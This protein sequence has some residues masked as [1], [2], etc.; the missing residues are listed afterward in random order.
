MQENILLCIYTL[1]HVEGTQQERVRSI[2]EQLTGQSFVDLKATL[3]AMRNRGE[4]EQKSY[5][6]RTDSYDY[7]ISP[8]RLI[9]LMIHYYEEEPKLTIQVLEAA[10]SMETTSVQRMLWQFISTGYSDI[11]IEIIS[12]YQIS[13]RLPYFMPAVADKRFAPLLMVFSLGNFADL[14]TQTIMEAIEDEGIIDA[15]H[16]RQLVVL[17]RRD[18]DSLEEEM[19]LHEVLC[20]CGLYTYLADGRMPDYVHLDDKYH[21]I[22]A[23]IR[24]TYRGNMKNALTMFRRSLKKF[25]STNG[26]YVSTKS[27]L[28]LSIANFYYI[29]AC[30]KDGSDDSNKK[31]LAIAKSTDTRV[32][33]AAKVLYNILYGNATDKQILDRLNLL[34]ASRHGINRVLATLMCRYVGKDFSQNAKPQWAILIHEMSP[35]F[36]DLS[37]PILKKTPFGEAPLLSAIHHRKQWENVLSDLTGLN[38]KGIDV[39]IRQVRVSRVAY[40]LSNMKANNVTPR[41]QTI[42]KNGTWGS[43]KLL[44]INSFMHG[45]ADGMCDA[46]HRIADRVLMRSAESTSDGDTIKLEDVLP[47]MTEESRLYVGRYAPYS[48]VEVIEEVPYISM[49]HDKEGFLI[50]SNV[51]PS[52]VEQDI[53]I[54]HRGAASIN[55]IHMTDRQR[56][57]YRRLLSI[58]RFPNEAEPQLRRFLSGLGGQIEVHSDLI[59]GGSTLPI[60]DGDSRLVLQ[61]RPDRNTR[62]GESFYSVSLFVRPLQ[63]G[64]IKCTPGEG[65]EVIIDNADIRTRVKRDLAKEKENLDH[66]QSTIDSFQL[67]ENLLDSASL[68]PLIEYAQANPDRISCE[69]P[70]GAKMRIKQRNS[71]IAWNGTIKKNDNGWFEL[72]GDI[73]LDQEKVI[74]MAQLL[75]LARQSKGRYIPLGNGDYLALSEKLRRQLNQLSAIVSRHHGH[76]QMSPFTAALLEPDITTGEL[77]ITEDAELK[78][79]RQRIKESSTY[80]PEVPAT[81]HATLREYQLEGYQWISRLNYW[82]AGALLADDMGLGKTI[83]TIAFLLAKAEEGPALVVAPASVAPNWKVEFEKFAPSLRVTLLNFEQDRNEAICQAKA[84]DVI[85]CTYMLLLSVKD[86][87][88]KKEWTTICLDEAHIIK[89]RGAKTSAVAMKLKSRNRIMLTGTPVQNHLGELWNLFQF[90]NPGLLGSFEEFN[91]RFIIPIEQNKDQKVQQLLDR[92]VKPFMLRRTK[93]K[94]A[95]ELPDKEEIYQHVTMSEEEQLTYEAL[96]QRAEAMLD[97]NLNVNVNTLAEITRLR[98]AA[99]GQSKITAMLELLQ[100]VLEGGDS[101][102]IFSQFTTYLSQIQQALKNFSIPYIYIDG[103]VPIKERQ[104]LVEKFQAG[105]C[106]VFLISLKAGGLGL[107]LTRANYVIHMDPWWNP[108]IE[109]QATDRSHR[110]GQRQAVTVYHLISQGTIEEK[111]QRL[112]QRKQSLVSDILSATDTSHR[113]TGEELLEMIRL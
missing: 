84:G 80:S 105:E 21:E 78:Q 22:L 33:A 28:P 65:N 79:I 23:G 50:S 49:H 92:L 59:E 113:L 27:Y 1:F 26:F 63:G 102:L 97:A 69:W 75:E 106:P 68:L 36:D 103:T 77:T 73:Q 58:D 20:L 53:I 47:E 56:P 101:V 17:F 60:C 10:R 93:D 31:A 94:V 39:P 62:G 83:Q 30:Y 104:R 98:L 35:Y 45:G 70:E 100:T 5:N 87:L 96:R 46:D 82:G 110:I 38:D 44:N 90:V 72:E 37:M 112:H 13:E 14:L 74:S 108:A 95:R 42:L 89:N 25:N 85:V 2:V 55:F 91:R 6:W 86:T 24:D 57:Y 29:L 40:Y 76:L 16:I 43:G 61:M 99:C 88:V 54:T 41:L 15:Q 12:D 52:E 34:Y 107:N 8:K 48:I 11:N 4:L 81:L 66:L 9:P 67:E 109:A 64:R 7:V 51:N 18:D 111:I 71:T 3:A 19:I 32:T